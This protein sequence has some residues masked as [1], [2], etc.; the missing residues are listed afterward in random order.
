LSAS[1]S[2][3]ESGCG[4]VADGDSKEVRTGGQAAQPVDVLVELRIGGVPC[5]TQDGVKRLANQ[6]PVPFFTDPVVMANG[7]LSLEDVKPGHPPMMTVRRDLV[8]LAQDEHIGANAEMAE[9]GEPAPPENAAGGPG[10]AGQIVELR[11]AHLVALRLV[12]SL[13]LGGK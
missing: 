4:C 11:D 1:V 10:R 8:S 13:H 9:Q 6:E 5:R 12:Q 7:H 3:P 2:T